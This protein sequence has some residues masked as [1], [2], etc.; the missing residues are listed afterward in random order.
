LK[1]ALSSQAALLLSYSKPLKPAKAFLSAMNNF[2]G[3]ITYSPSAGIADYLQKL[4]SK[5]PQRC[6]RMQ[7]ASTE[8]LE[9][10][11]HF[12][13]S[14]LNASA[15]GQ[16]YFD[17]ELF[18]GD[19]IAASIGA[20]A[21]ERQNAA[22]LL[23]ALILK[24]GVDAL[25]KVNGQFLILYVD[26]AQKIIRLLTDHSGVQ[27]VFYH[28]GADFFI[29]ASDIRF[30]L[31]HPQCPSQ[32]D[33][34]SS[35]RR[36]R[37]YTV[38]HSYRSYSTWFKE[39]K[40]LPEAVECS[41]NYRE[42]KVSQ[43]RFW[44]GLY[45][46]A[47]PSASDKR[48]AGDVM[49]EYMALL[50]DAVRIRT[51]DAG[52]AHS[53]LSGGLDSS[54]I[55]AMAAKGRPLHSYSIVTQT[56]VLEDTTSVCHKLAGDLG[57]S[58]EQFLIPY[59]EL[60]YD[61]QRWKSRIWRTESPVN[62]TDALTKNL[63]HYAI[64]NHHPEVPYV[65]TGTGSDQYNGG[66]VRWVMADEDSEARSAETFLK[67]VKD[68]GLQQ[69]AGRDEDTYWRLRNVVRPE[70]IAESAGGKLQSNYWMYYA[71]SALHSETYSL[72]WDELRAASA[73]GRSVRF[74]FLDY[75]FAQFF[76]SV[77]EQLHKE[78][79]YDKQI[80]RVPA[81]KLL[82]SYVTEKAK[83][84]AFIPGYDL[85]FSLFNS[86]TSGPDSLLEQAFGGR[87]MQHP[88]I[89]IEQL[90]ARVEAMKQQPEIYEWQEL[91]Q[92]INLGL[93]EQLAGQDEASLHFEREMEAPELIRFDK[94]AETKRSLEKRLAV[95]TEAELLAQ[96]LQ[97]AGGC[98]LMQDYKT[99]TLF[100]SK[101]NTLA[102]EL[103][104]EYAEWIALLKAIDGAKSTQQLLAETAGTF[105]DI[106]EFFTL[107]MK[108]Q[109]LSFRETTNAAAAQA[110]ADESIQ[111]KQQLATQ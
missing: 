79:F 86:L 107:A 18:N 70:F 99:G 108:E 17:G 49:E 110:G 85:R 109:L 1:Q 59:H 9:A 56:T 22:T 104:E 95:K 98:G 63:L 50:E 34:E 12:E 92:I 45:D 54:V 89:D 38:M 19:D 4:R 15:P 87:S 6:A 103:D 40:L 36:P 60:V 39:I 57:F 80:L 27:Q 30:L 23:H 31:A 14:A 96:P 94:P 35:L 41:I 62:H 21:T 88:V 53:F 97:F 8:G 46:Y 33:W 68:A 55:C 90:W 67:K 64:S 5:F 47:P 84:P 78:L 24:S 26:A 10:I 106:R 25:S 74:P 77:P 82:P 93:L 66:L 102:Y 100:L 75:R 58:N 105:E 42:K 43:R 71:Q 111:L 61:K 2:A 13:T 29:F 65:L 44:N 73:H 91:I 76:A 7:S 3:I 16:L 72:L 37:G 28:Q 11:G 32:I 20:T 83:A 52:D 69:F 48:K 101:N 81:R 51:R